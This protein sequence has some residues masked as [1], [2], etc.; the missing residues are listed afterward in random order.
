ML[1]KRGSF[2]PANWYG[3]ALWTIRHNQGRL[4]RFAPFY[5]RGVLT[6][7]GLDDYLSA[8][9]ALAHLQGGRTTDARTVLDRFAATD[10]VDIR[11]NLLWTVK[12]AMLCEAAEMTG[13]ATAGTQLVELLRPLSGTLAA[14][15]VLVFAP[16][17]LAVAQASLAAGDYPS[18]ETFAA[19]A[20]AASR[21]RRTPIFLGRELIRVAA[22]R[23]QLGGDSEAITGPV[24]EALDIADRTEAALIRREAEHYDLCARFDS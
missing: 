9:L 4:A 16:I 18:A 23:K 21:Q 8:I 3:S 11:P 6:Q 24:A 12:L 17:D 7:P 22:A 15:A 20:V 2:D 19:R 10:F 14:N 1:A 5:R 13:H